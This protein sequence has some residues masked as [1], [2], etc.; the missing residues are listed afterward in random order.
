MTFQEAVDEWC[1]EHSVKELA[2]LVG[3][4]LGCI[5][6]YRDGTEPKP[7]RKQ[8]IINII[9]YKEEPEKYLDS[10]IEY[11]KPKEASIRLGMSIPHIQA[12]MRAKEL[13][14]GLVFQGSGERYNYYIIR[15]DFEDFIEKHKMP[16]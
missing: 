9:G 1:F 13:P 2:E 15:K 3:C 8:K 11:V 7:E 16:Q 12:A 5:S 6:S 14:I 4:S 10:E